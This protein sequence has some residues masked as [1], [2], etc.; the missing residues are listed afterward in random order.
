[1]KLRGLG[2]QSKMIPNRTLTKMASRK[3]VWV[4]GSG[5]GDLRCQA[6]SWVA[7]KTSLTGLGFVLRGV[8]LR[9]VDAVPLTHL[10]LHFP[11]TWVRVCLIFCG[12]V[13]ICIPWLQSWQMEKSPSVL[14][15]MSWWRKGVS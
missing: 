11:N 10:L 5:A 1:M 2:N 13:L 3:L 8:G 6:G 14:S 7:G 12:V 9:T 15:V 4:K